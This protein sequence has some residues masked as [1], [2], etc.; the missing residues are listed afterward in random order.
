[1]LFLLSQSEWIFRGEL[2]MLMTEF[3]LSWLNNAIKV[4]AKWNWTLPPLASH[5]SGSSGSAAKPR[6]KG[7]LDNDPDRCCPT[8]QRVAYCVSLFKG[9]PIYLV[10]S[11]VFFFHRPAIT[12][13]T[14][15]RHR[16]QL[17]QLGAKPEQHRKGN[18]KHSSTR[19]D[20]LCLCALPKS[21]PVLGYSGVNVDTSK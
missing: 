20:K 12:P 1:M 18:P 5:T 15:N 10:I 7:F 3:W 16:T 13:T 21:W 8:N 2:H 19:C 17:Q 6:H 4:L 14:E 11:L 9:T